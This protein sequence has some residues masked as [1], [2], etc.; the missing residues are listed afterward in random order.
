MAI[1]DEVRFALRNWRKS[2][3]VAAAV[4]ATLAIAIGANT[5]VFSAANAVLLRP[6]PIVDPGRIVVMW[7]TSVGRNQPVREVSHRNFVDW[8]AQSRSFE[9]MAAMASVTW[10]SVLDEGGH[11]TRVERAGVSGSFFQ[12]LGAAPLLGRTLRPDDDTRGAPDVAVLSHALWEQRFGADR[13]IV[14]AR[15][16][17]NDRAYTVVGVMPRGFSYPNGAELWTAVVPEIARVQ[18]APNLDA[19]EARHY[20]LLYVIGRLARDATLADARTEIDAVVR[21]LPEFA[22]RIAPTEAVVTVTPLLDHM[23]GQVRLALMLLL[24]LVVLVLVAACANVS[25]LLLTRATARRRETAVRVAMGATRARVLREWLAETAIVTCAGTLAGLLL[26]DGAL[27]GLLALAPPGITGLEHATIDARIA[28]YS[29]AVAAL[30]MVICAIAPAWHSAAY[31]ITQALRETR[32]TEGR[33]SRRTRHLLIVAQLAIAT[34]LLIAAG[35]LVR[36]FVAL[37]QLDLGFDPDR[38]LTLTVEPQSQPTARYRAIYETVL[39]RVSAIPRV[40]AAGA[41]YLRPLAHG[42][43]GM[44]NGALLEGQHI[45]QPE[46]W[47]NNPTLNFQAVTPGYFEAMRIRRLQGRLFSRQDDERSAGAVIVSESTARRLWPGQNALGKRMSLAGGRTED[48]KFPWQTV[49]GVVADVRYRGLDDVRFDVY[50]PWRQTLNR[51]K[52]LM[53][54]TSSDPLATVAAVRAAVSEAGDRVLVE[55]A[56]TMDIVVSTAV[57]PWRFSMTIFVVL[58][59]I[60]V[61]LGAFGLFGVVAYAVTQRTSDLA[62]R[63]ALGARP[64]Q[65]LRMMLWEGGRLALMGVTVGAAAFFLV[66]DS[67]TGLL[68]QVEPSEPSTLGTVAALLSGITLTATYLAAR[69]AM[70]IDPMTVLRAD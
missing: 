57:A 61:A 30:V 4:V 62:L 31:P 27:R 5:A 70:R 10:S 59:A 35:L 63:L 3:A 69:R 42:A 34:T 41:V 32:S 48:G 19:S 22:A 38:V 51:V 54:R 9:S 67:L 24:A 40:Q 23:F 26:A 60:G 29:A 11:L 64:G 33:E 56:G 53:I 49:V 55:H 20:G 8:R 50:M 46:T 68:F 21:G 6:L 66:S 7:E 65:L 43:I 44:D 1:A 12:L 18:A 16:R 45:D 14:G 13:R 47:R 36:S 2:P 25:T 28:S 37:R 15:L 39:E 52:H 17:L 58:A